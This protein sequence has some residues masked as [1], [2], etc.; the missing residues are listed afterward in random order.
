MPSL[1]FSRNRSTGS[2]TERNSH[3]EHTVYLVEA[4]DEDELAG[5][6]ASH[7]QALS[8]HELNGW[9]PDPALWP[10]DRSLTTLEEW[11]SSELYTVVVDTGASPLE[12]N[13]Q[14]QQRVG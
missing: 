4:D 9:Y 14:R 1:T 7:H 5:W 6:L 12:D 3:Q 13:P 2:V 11:F 8:E 10:R